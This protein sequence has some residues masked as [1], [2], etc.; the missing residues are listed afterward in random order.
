[1]IV[2][3]EYRAGTAL[4]DRTE[5]IDRPSGSSLAISLKGSIHPLRVV[6]SPGSCSI[7]HV[8]VQTSSDVVRLP[9]GEG[10]NTPRNHRCEGNV[11]TKR[12][13]HEQTES[14]VAD[15]PAK[16]VR[17]SDVRLGGRTV[18]CFVF[19]HE[20]M[21]ALHP[22]GF[23]W[24]LNSSRPFPASTKSGSNPYTVLSICRPHPTGSD[25]APSFSTHRGVSSG[26]NS[27]T[28]P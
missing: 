8:L 27:R 25:A 14:L 10:S 16:S 7:G 12:V 3:P 13:G 17:P 9:N 24:M 20:R 18:G 28:P 5:A 6:N 23:G 22:R 11:E 21:G 1:M 19:P 15:V 4:C 2:A 26:A